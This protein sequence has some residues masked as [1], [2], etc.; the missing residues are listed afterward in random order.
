MVCL[1]ATD[2]RDSDP[3]GVGGWEEGGQQ[4]L[5]TYKEGSFRGQRCG[6]FHL[7]LLGAR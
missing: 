2:N 6:V 5:L 7:R 3:M 1:L 4:L